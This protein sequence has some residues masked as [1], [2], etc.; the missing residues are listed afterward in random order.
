[1]IDQL[2]G[3]ILK[4]N[5]AIPAQSNDTSV[6]VGVKLTSL[7]AAINHQLGNLTLLV[8]KTGQMLIAVFCDFCVA[9]SKF[10]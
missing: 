8:S 7:C 6:T 2:V 5:K 10:A 4:S 3:S 9:R 1:M